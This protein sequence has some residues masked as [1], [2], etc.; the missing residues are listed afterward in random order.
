MEKQTIQEMKDRPPR[1]LVSK[2]ELRP[3]DILCAY[4]EREENDW[5]KLAMAIGRAIDGVGYNH[6]GLFDGEMVIE[7]GHE[8][9]V[10][11]SPLSRILNKSIYTDIHRFIADDKRSMLGDEGWPAKPVIDTAERYIGD[12]YSTADAVLAAILLLTQRA[13]IVDNK[14]TNLI[15]GVLEK[16][17]RYLQERIE[18]TPPESLLTCSELVYRAFNEAPPGQKYEIRVRS[19]PYAITDIR[20]EASRLD[21]DGITIPFVEVMP[22]AESFPELM[23]QKATSHPD[24][25]KDVLK[26]A[27]KFEALYREVH[28]DSPFSID[29]DVSADHPEGEYMVKL[30]P[31]ADYVSPGD[32]V[33]SWNTIEIGRIENKAKKS[34]ADLI[35][36]RLRRRAG[37]DRP[38]RAE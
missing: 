9:G 17:V 1:R 20:D 18:G 16:A 22:F 6:C 29:L 2:A 21:D 4:G 11:R 38:R 37:K 30:Q 31:V 25:V 10:V 28:G 32:L 33:R 7:T 36:S 15:R 34:C 23:L 14:L 8:K 12:Q 24:V 19:V 13:L 26:L 5:L 27:K 35:L 3:G